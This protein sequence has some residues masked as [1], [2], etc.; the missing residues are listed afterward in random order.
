MDDRL[1]SLADVARLAGV[2]RPAASNWRRRHDDFP[3]P[4]QETGAASL[5]SLAEVNAWLVRHGKELAPPSVRAEVAA[6]LN[7]VRGAVT[8]TAAVETCLEIL[9]GGHDLNRSHVPELP[10]LVKEHGARAVCEALLAEAA[11]QER[12]APWLLPAMGLIDLLMALAGPHLQGTVYDPACGLASL[13]LAVHRTA[14][15]RVELVGDNDNNGA[16]RL[17][18]LRA[19]IHDAHATL[20]TGGWAQQT[21][22][23]T[24]LSATTAGRDA[25]AV[26]RWAARSL[27]QGGHG[28][29]VSPHSVLVRDGDYRRIRRD[30][31]RDGMVEAVIE[32]PRGL[33]E[34][35]T[36]RSALWL[37]RP[38]GGATAPDVLLLD[39]SG[40]HV[41]P[42]DVLAASDIAAIVN[43]V[44]TWQ[45]GG[46]SGGG[47]PSAVVEKERLVAGECR[48][49]VVSWLGVGEAPRAVE[50]FAA[51][52]LRVGQAVVELA[53]A[54]LPSELLEVDVRQ[55]SV[56]E[57]V[58]AAD[59]ELF[60][61]ARIAPVLGGGATPVIGEGDV[62]D[63]WTAVPT[64]TA[65]L[66]ITRRGVPTTRRGD[67]VISAGGER[68]RAAV[69]EEE[70]AVVLAPLQC[71]RLREPS[72]ARA[73]V[74]AAVLSAGQHPVRY[75]EVRDLVV[76]WPDDEQ[77]T[78]I[79]RMLDALSDLSRIA[80]E[81]AAAVESLKA[82]ALA[83][84]SDGAVPAEEVP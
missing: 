15:G 42:G 31:V 6:A 34:G 39:A 47:F 77:C 21:K 13:L 44:R 63:E 4:V 10:R 52:R 59:A 19:G 48:M 78:R 41:G 75:A 20:R 68:V 60:R 57:L 45:K 55:R 5:F 64:T 9:A 50:R 27:N 61:G 35:T 81:A 84:F 53:A 38:P 16:T 62:R 1:V 49:D 72:I 51:A 2:T 12:R 33:Y 65:E 29:Q 83:A 26:L 71:L 22:A 73:R 37:L 18:A 14:R 24:V 40:V 46:T 8:V 80:A 36:S 67:I 54:A 79:T 7:Q 66:D 3:K 23:D 11:D 17:A 25:G 28:F 74:I 30:L 43:A 32:L 56:R 58:R 76:P 82:D 70:D 69:V